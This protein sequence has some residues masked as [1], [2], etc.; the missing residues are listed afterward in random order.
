MLSLDP[1]WG[2]LP[3]GLQVVPQLPQ[4]GEGGGP[5][6]A[7][8]CAQFEQAPRA[9]GEAPGNP[10]AAPGPQAEGRWSRPCQPL[11]GRCLLSHRNQGHFSELPITHWG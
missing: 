6:R 1:D 7:L 2:D 5:G 8:S 3:S 9:A 10:L 11:N 4:K